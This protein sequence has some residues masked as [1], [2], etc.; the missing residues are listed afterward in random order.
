MQLMSNGFE[1]ILEKYGILAYT[2]K[3]TSMLPMLRPERDAFI[4]S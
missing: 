3:G 4:I 2:N 1:E